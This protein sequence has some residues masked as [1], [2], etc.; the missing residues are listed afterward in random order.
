MKLTVSKNTQT[1]G[2]YDFEEMISISDEITFLIGRASDCHVV[3]DDK[4]ISRNHIEINFD[5]TS[6]R[7]KLNSNIPIATINNAP[8]N[9]EIKLNNNDVL[10]LGEY[11]IEFRI[12]EVEVQEPQSEVAPVI[13]EP[14]AEESKIE[15]PADLPTDN[16]QLVEEETLTEMVDE[17]V[18]DLDELDDLDD[19]DNLDDLENLDDISLDEETP[20]DEATEEPQEE[21]DDLN[22]DGEMSLDDGDEAQVESE[23]ATEIYGD[24]APQDDEQ[25][26]EN[27]DQQDGYDDSNYSENGEAVE[28]FDDNF[29]DGF[30]EGEYDE[31]QDDDNF[32]VSELDDGDSTQVFTGFA[33]Y[34]M[35]LFG[36]N[37]PYDTYN[38]TEEQVIIGRDPEKCQ[39]VL[40]DPEVSTTH[41][42]IK[43][44]GGVCIL[45]DLK[46]ANGTILNGKRINKKEIINEDE[47][48]IGS[49]TFT[50]Y[51]GNDFIDSQKETLMPVEEN[52]EVVVEE[53]VEVKDDDDDIDFDG[54]EVIEEDG[55][56]PAD[57]SLVGKFKALPTPRKII[58]I[59]VAA[60]VAFM[61]L[62]EDSGQVKTTPKK[63]V[64]K[65]K[66]DKKAEQAKS[67]LSPEIIAERDSYYQLAK[68]AVDNRDFEAASFNLDK[69]LALDPD[70]LQARQLSKVVKNSLA[71]I[72]ELNEEK[73]KEEEAEKRRKE[74]A[75]L[76]KRAT[77]AVKD[78]N[79]ELSRKLFQQIKI[80]DPRNF[81]VTALEA[82]L[83]G[84][85]TQRNKEK[86]EKAQ[87]EAER[88]RMVSQLQPGKALFL[89]EDWY[90]AIGE[91]EKFMKIKPMDE[92]LLKEGAEM[93]KKSKENLKSVIAPLL[94][95][96][97]SLK[98]GEDLKAAYQTY[99]EALQYDPSLIEALNEM[100]QIDSTLTLRSKRVYREAII[101]ES[102]GL[103]E[104]AKSKYQEV[105]QIA[106]KENEYYRKAT[107]RL[108]SLL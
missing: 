107:E 102:L 91:L 43:R 38:I 41:A 68:T 56:A 16:I 12:P 13:E 90:S 58:Y 37:A 87:D 77:D 96:A 85:I 27:Y 72:S 63:Q 18:D 47:F 21:V 81:D 82:E 10:I 36:E 105:Q 61:F 50:V 31:Y 89:K 35:E 62:P 30:A 99:S 4:K 5:G 3:I 76:V 93:L 23:Q 33:K 57:N 95:K 79:I 7:L 73:R 106:P 103:Y 29:N 48:I 88:K 28:G 74:V 65:A 1:I 14:K 20:S 40:N 69:A 17:K 11:S 32:A 22:F 104:E 9:S 52:Q 8:I 75:D 71:K 44:V 42:I 98:E 53:I 59:F 60:A 100:A 92:D 24:S 6:Y 46:S 2:E 39:I 54:D 78:R 97:R 101:S 70:F 108:E 86:L 84:W 34:S 80:K 19:L 83:E 25:A 15:I 49:T 64:A 67:K 94:G 66:D 55:Y 51:V 26:Y 45:E